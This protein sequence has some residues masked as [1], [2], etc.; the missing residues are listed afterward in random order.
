MDGF[1]LFRKCCWENLDAHHKVWFEAAQ[2]KS[3]W[4]DIGEAFAQ[5]WDNTG[6]QKKTTYV[7]EDNECELSNQSMKTINKTEGLT[8]TYAHL[9]NNALAIGKVVT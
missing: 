7:I 8:V 6:Q 4:K 2:E 5:K 1:A 3:V 9:Y